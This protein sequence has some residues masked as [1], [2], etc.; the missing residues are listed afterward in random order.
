MLTENAEC[1]ASLDD[2]AARVR[3]HDVDQVYTRNVKS[4]EWLFTDKTHFSRWLTDDNNLYDPMFWITGKPGS[5][6]STLMRYALES[7]RSREMLPESTGEPIA[8]F[9]HLRGKAFVQKSLYGMLKEVLFGLLKQFEHFFG[10]VRPIFQRMRKNFGIPRWD[11][12]SLTEMLLEVPNLKSTIPGRKDRIVLFIDA[13]DENQD[14]KDNVTMIGTL[15][16]LSSLYADTRQ[17][18]RSP[19]LKIC[20]ASRPWPIFMNELG[21]NDRIPSFAIHDFTVNDIKSYS[22]SLLKKP[23][24]QSE[25]IDDTQSAVI[26]LSQDITIRAKGVFVWVRIVVDNL[27]Q[28][29]TD[30]TPVT[31]LQQIISG[32]PEEL[33]DFY[34]YTISRIPPEYCQETEAALKVILGSRIDLTLQELFVIVQVC[35]GNASALNSA[36]PEVTKSWL[37]SRSG[38]LIEVTNTSLNQVSGHEG[39]LRV[40]FIHQTAQDFVREGISGL[41]NTLRPGEAHFQASG[42]RLIELACLDSHP[43]YY[44][45][46]RVSKQLFSYLRDVEREI[47][48]RP[49]TNTPYLQCLQEWGDFTLHKFPAYTRDRGRSSKL[50]AEVEDYSYYLE[51]QDSMKWGSVLRDS[52]ALRNGSRPDLMTVSQNLYH[53]QAYSGSSN[54]PETL[55]QAALGPRLSEDRLD[56]PR[57]LRRLLKDFDK[58][59]LDK[60]I[61]FNEESQHTYL[62]SNSLLTDPRWRPSPEHS[63]RHS[64]TAL[65]HCLAVA[66]R[67]GEISSKDIL[68]MAQILLDAGANAKYSPRVDDHTMPTMSLLNFCARYK[69]DMSERWVKLLRLYGATL[70]AAEEEIFNELV[71]R[72]IFGGRPART[73]DPEEAG[74][75]SAVV[76]AMVLS[77]LCLSAV[78]TGNNAMKGCYPTSDD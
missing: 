68:K 24:S 36:E 63:E 45:L 9:F 48:T 64:D 78:G 22:M 73:L 17:D 49:H 19:V 43:P 76:S 29:I 66:E 3:V 55:L 12:Q 20:L 27:R 62:G 42:T 5:G 38:G 47:D 74:E 10:L 70:L 52:Y 54:Q 59:N 1:L 13:L 6:K 30:G 18:V 34:K 26:R 69:G 61:I 53:T 37:N 58:N 14:Q 50:G 32:Y 28:H 33:K 11:I 4:F 16:L 25:E 75:K 77:G 15:K 46:R 2:E 23:V 60:D 65:I 41:P 40:Q 8:Y 21:N 71:Q 56:R 39:S 57:M 31:S 7:P 35:I 67:G 51:D 44:D 72:S